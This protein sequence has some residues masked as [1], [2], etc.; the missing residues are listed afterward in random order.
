MDVICLWADF[1]SC[2]YWLFWV[3]TPTDMGLVT[4]PFTERSIHWNLNDPWDNGSHLLMIMRQMIIKTSNDHHQNIIGGS[5]KFLIRHYEKPQNWYR[6]FPNQ[7][8]FSLLVPT[9][10]PH[11][12]KSD[13]LCRGIYLIGKTL[14]TCIFL[15]LHFYDVIPFRVKVI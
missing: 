15:D 7:Q 12:H 4:W 6:K 14:F 9:S 11:I 1:L 10:L 5:N 13:M 2:H 3:V 8:N